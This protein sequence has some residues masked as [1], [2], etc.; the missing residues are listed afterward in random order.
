VLKSLRTCGAA[1][2]L[3]LALVF[4]SVTARAEGVLAGTDI[5]NIA[6]VTYSVGSVSTTTASNQVTLRVAEI[7]D[8]EVTAQAPTTGVPANSGDAQQAVRFL[9]TNTGNATET[10][11]LVMTSTIAGDQFDPTPASPSIYFDTDNSNSLT[12]AD[13]PYV[14]GSNDPVLSADGAVTVLVVNDIPAGLVDG[15]LGRTR[16]TAQARTGMGAPGTVYAAQGNGINGAVVDAVVGASGADDEDQIDYLITGVSVTAVKTQAVI[17]QFGGS[18]PVPGARIN[19]SI[20]INMTGSGTAT[21]AVFSDEIP[22]NTTYVPGTLSLNS[23]ALSDAADADAGEFN[24]AAP[25]RV[26]VTLGDLTSTTGPQTVT[27]AVT[28]NAN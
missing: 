12:A 16:L 19:Y 17:D 18:S 28:I 22:A 9:V 21:A 14:A 7:L 24:S 4:A 13:T 10:F 27:F 20:V 8:V 25:A 2:A 26:R 23:T 6:E 11:R 5:Q 3:S 15:N 1:S